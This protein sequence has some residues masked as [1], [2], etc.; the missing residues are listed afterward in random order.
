MKDINQMVKEQTSFMNK[1]S[2][3]YQEALKNR[4]QRT[5][6]DYEISSN[7]YAFDISKEELL[8]GVKN[9]EVASPIQADGSYRFVPNKKTTYIYTPMTD[10]EVEESR[11]KLGF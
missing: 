3:K 9:V 1:A 7:N 6:N 2:S 8:K 5:A 11:R 10:K 4:I